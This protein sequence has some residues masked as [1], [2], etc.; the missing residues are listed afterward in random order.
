[1]YYIYHIPGTKIGTSI[2]PAYRVAQQGYNQFDVLEVHADIYEASDR[3]IEL[4]KEYGYK[5]DKIPYWKSIQN[6]PKWNSQTAKAAGSISPTN[7][8]NYREGGRIAM[9]KLA[10]KRITC[11]HCGKESNP[12]NHKQHHGDNCKLSLS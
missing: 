5:V 11:E 3:E 4:Q 1:M 2:E 6:R 9:A 12:G 8:D 10:A 7:T